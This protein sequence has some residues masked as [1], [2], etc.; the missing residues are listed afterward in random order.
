[1]KPVVVKPKKAGC[2]DFNEENNKEGPR[3][4]YVINDFNGEEIVRKWY[5]KE[6]QKKQIKTV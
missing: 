5:E 4:T 6:L 1:M 2:I 3:R